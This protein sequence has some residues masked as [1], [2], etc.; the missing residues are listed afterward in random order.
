MEEWDGGLEWVPISDEARLVAAKGHASVVE[1]LVS[2]CRDRLSIH[3]QDWGGKTALDLA[4]MNG[5]APDVER[6]LG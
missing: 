6:W 5:Y 3:V 4:A 2:L 1:K